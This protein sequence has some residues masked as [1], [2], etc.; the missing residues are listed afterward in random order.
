MLSSFTKTQYLLVPWTDASR[1]TLRELASRGYT[2]DDIA[3]TMHVNRQWL[4]WK[5][6]DDPATREAWDAGVAEHK[7]I[8]KDGGPI[9]D[10]LKALAAAAKAARDART[11][12]RME[13]LVSTSR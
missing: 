3:E 8:P 11:K 6:G 12:R 5:I 10:E 13:N 1:A 7:S 2:R 4:D 9:S